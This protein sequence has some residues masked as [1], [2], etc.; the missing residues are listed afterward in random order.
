MRI[1]IDMMGGDY[2]PS[3][4]IRGSILARKALPDD[5]EIILIGD[6]EVYSRY[7][8]ENHLDVSGLSIVHTSDFVGMEDHPL[9]V[10]KEK[11]KASLFLGSQML[12][13]GTIDGFCSSG[14]TGAML[15]GAMQIVTSIPGI[16]RPAIAAPI[17][18]IEGDRSLMLDVGLNPDARPD[19]LYQYGSIGTIYSKLVHGIEEPNVALLN[20]GREESKGNMV[21]RSTY[22][23]MKDS[24]AYN[25]I[26]NFEANEMFVSNRAHVIVT[27]GFVGN[28]LLKE[29][30]A[31]Y[32]LVSMKGIGNDYF[33]MFNFENF[34]GTPILGV[35]AP[36]II[37]HGISN[38]KAIKNMLLHTAEV[39][40]ADLVNRIKEELER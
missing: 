35:C 24:S 39:V 29:A 28:M 26:G 22:Q 25:F 40:G 14:N 21:S 19:V 23:L 8:E 15:V 12:V 4:T 38:E 27:D 7:S 31:F 11:P 2:A 37:G 34:G 17:P 18:N 16:I 6:Q 13:D 10:F 5:V 20:V 9:K 3:S 30:E 33:E 36:L 32:T 1:G